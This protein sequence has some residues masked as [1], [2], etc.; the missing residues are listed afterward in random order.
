MPI[1]HGLA[2]QYGDQLDF[3]VVDKTEP[4]AAERIAGYDFDVHGMV[5]VDQ[6]DRVV[7]KEE[8]HTQTRAR[9]AA[10]IDA[11]LK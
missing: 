11:A 2:E 10:A 3:E 9:V 8:G 5:I 1:V 6:N 4:G 7:W